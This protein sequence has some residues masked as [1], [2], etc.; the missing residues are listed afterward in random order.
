M[1]RT[2]AVA[3]VVL[4]AGAGTRYGMPKVLAGQGAWL[5]AAV[6]ALA[7][8]GCDDVVV[9]LGA[10]MVDVPPP[11]RVVVAEDWQTGMS[12]SLRA[13]LDAA[14]GAE[15]ALLHL[16]DTPDVGADVVARVLD[17][18]GASISGLA[19]ATYGGR[20]GHPVAIARRHWAALLVTLDGDEGGRTFLTSRN[21]V[22]AV[23]CGDLA[24]GVDVDEL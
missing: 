13:G 1:S 21:D 3:G 7:D 20:P 12:A 2:R 16:V 24:S 22:V 17:G 18:V 14:G 15:V 9:V 6:E 8:G 10:A 23:E 11:A 19:R 5:R 4:A